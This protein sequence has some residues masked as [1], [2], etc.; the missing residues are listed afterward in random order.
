[1]GQSQCFVPHQANEREIKRTQIHYCHSGPPNRLESF[2]IFFA[3]PG[4][5]STVLVTAHRAKLN[6][7]VD[8]SW[9][10]FLKISLILIKIQ[11]ELV[12]LVPSEEGLGGAHHHYRMHQSHGKL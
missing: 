9:E 11:G 4:L 12:L 3:D 1:M 7:L 10:G 6:L 2:K 8:F 5:H